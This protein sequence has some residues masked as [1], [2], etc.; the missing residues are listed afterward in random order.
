MNLLKIENHEF[1]RK[2][3]EARGWES[4]NNFILCGLSYKLKQNE[5]MKICFKNKNYDYLCRVGQLSL[6]CP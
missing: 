4:K 3:W 5:K 6:S 2:Q 1:D